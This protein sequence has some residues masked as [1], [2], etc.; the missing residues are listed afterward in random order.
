MNDKE[1]DAL[2]EAMAN[3]VDKRLVTELKRA[4]DLVTVLQDALFRPDGRHLYFSTSCLHKDHD[5]CASMTGQQ[6]R[7]RPGRCKFCD[8]LCVCPCHVTGG[9][10][11]G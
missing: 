11:G 7:K 4:N 5:Y 2:L 10:R 9:P 1:I 6:G 8:E 3:G